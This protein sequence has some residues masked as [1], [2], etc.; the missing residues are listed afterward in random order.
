[1]SAW[2]LP[3]LQRYRATRYDTLRTAEFALEGLERAPDGEHRIAAMRNVVVFGRS[4]TFVLRNI[5]S[6]APSFAQ[7][8]APWQAEMARD[9]LILY[10]KDLRNEIE[11]QGK[12]RTVVSTYIRSFR[13]PDDVPPPPPNAKEFFI[14][15]QFGG[16]GWQV[17]LEDGTLEK[18]YVTF[19]EG[20]IRTRLIFANLP[21]E[22]LGLRL[23]TPR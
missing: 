1:V 21:L 17:Q 4:V 13:Y 22:H 3:K 16:S 2:R 15:D 7:W 19:P 8:Y 9:P 14:G 10:M 18:M 12:A 23:A 6:A 20:Q 5:S 11:K